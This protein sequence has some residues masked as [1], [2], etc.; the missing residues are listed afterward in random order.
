MNFGI[1]YQNKI[2]TKFD[3]AYWKIAHGIICLKQTWNSNKFNNHIL[4][5]FFSSS[6]QFK[7]WREKVLKFLRCYEYGEILVSSNRW[8]KEK[9]L[10]FNTGLWKFKIILLFVIYFIWMATGNHFWH[11]P[12]SSR[13]VRQD[14]H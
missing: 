10:K 2:R 11:A 1:F 5:Y 6:F 9:N 14:A 12:H 3:D 13:V 4:T 7:C 8:P